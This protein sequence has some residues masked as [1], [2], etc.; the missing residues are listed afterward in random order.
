M[1]SNL[2]VGVLVLTLVPTVIAAP[3]PVLL[4][5]DDIYFTFELAK[6][7]LMGSKNVSMIQARAPSTSWAKS[8]S[9]A[10]RSSI[11]VSRSKETRSRFPRKS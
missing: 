11:S 10:R 2:S 7:P 1:R 3:S 9:R 6:A 4:G 5:S 8:A